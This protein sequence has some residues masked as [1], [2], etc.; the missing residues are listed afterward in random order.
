MKIQCSFSSLGK[1]FIVFDLVSCST[2]WGHWAT[3]KADIAIEITCL[4]SHSQLHESL[5]IFSAKMTESFVFLSVEKLLF[6][7]SLLLT[8]D[9]GGPMG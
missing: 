4:T 7:S 8:S 5:H 3:A 2:V 9:F 1:E 6:V